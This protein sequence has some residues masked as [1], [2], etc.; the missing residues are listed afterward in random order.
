MQTEINI[1]VTEFLT[2][3]PEFATIEYYQIENQLEI[4]NICHAPNPQIEYEKRKL[5]VM[6]AAAHL[7]TMTWMQ[8]AEIASQASTI[9]EGGGSRGL[10]AQ[11]NDFNLTHYG[12]MYLQIVK[13]TYFTPFCI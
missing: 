6:Y 5:A 4:A 7:L 3:F 9:A 11:E 2:K 1:I 12:R 10:I 8:A 13:T